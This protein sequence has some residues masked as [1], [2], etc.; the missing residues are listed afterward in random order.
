MTNNRQQPSNAL[1]ND[2]DFWLDMFS[3]DFAVSKFPSDSIQNY[4]SGKG[5]IEYTFQ[6]EL[7]QRLNQMA[8]G[9]EKAFFLILLSGIEYLLYRYTY[10]SPVVVAAPIFK[11]LGEGRFINNFLVYSSW[12]DQNLTFIDLLVQTKTRVSDVVSHQNYPLKNLIAELNFKSTSDKWPL[13]DVLVVLENIHQEQHLAEEGFNVSFRF[14]HQADQLLLRVEYN[15]GLYLQETVEQWVRHLE[16]LLTIVARSPETTLADIDLLSDAEKQKL[17]SCAVDADYPRD[18][19]IQQI[20]GQQVERF[21][22]RVA[23]KYQSPD[24]EQ[25]LELTYRELNQKANT[26]AQRLHSKGVRPGTIVGL[27]V[28]PS[29][30][31]VIGI[32]AILKAGGCYLPID[33]EYPRE[34]VEYMLADSQSSI[35]L[36]NSEIYTEFDYSGEIVNIAD[37]VVSAADQMEL[38]ASSGPND[39][40]Y[41]IYTSGSS[42]KPKGVLVE[43]R[44]VVRLFINDSSPF[45]FDEQ[46]IWLLFHSYCFDFSVWEMYGALLFGGK[47]IIIPRSTA[48]DPGESLRVIIGEGVTILNQTPTAFSNLLTEEFRTAERKLNLRYVIFGGEALK[49]AILREW[50]QRYPETKLINMYGITETTVHVTYKEITEVEIQHNLSNLGRPIPTLQVYILDSDLRLVPRGVIGEIVVGGVGVSRGYLNRP[51]LT[52]EK[53]IPDPFKP[54]NRLYRSGDLGRIL[55]S[56][57]IEY[58]GRRDRQIKIRGFR[59]ELGEVEYRLLSHPAIKTVHL[60]L[61]DNQIGEKDLWAYLVCEGEVTTAELRN[62]LA[63]HLPSYMYP[64]HFLQVDRLPLTDNG[65]IDQQALSIMGNELKVGTD[66]LLPKSHLEKELAELWAEVL[67]LIEVGIN[68][69]F[70]ECGGDS[71]KAVRL[72]TEINRRLDVGLEI[73]DLYRHQT[74]KELALCLEELKEKGDLGLTSVLQRGRDLLAEF[75]NNIANDQSLLKRLPGGMEDFYPLSPIQL[76]MVYYSNIKPEEPVYHDQFVYPVRFVNFELDKFVQSFKLMMSKHPILRTT[77]QMRHFAEPIQIVHRELEPVINFADITDLNRQEQEERINRYLKEED[78]GEKFR[79]ENNPLWRMQLFRVKNHEYYIIFSFHHSILDGWSVANLIPE[80]L[81]IY[82]KL[83]SGLEIQIQKLQHSYQDYVALLLGRKKNQEIGA[84]WQNKLRGYTRSKLPFNLSGKKLHNLYQSKIQRVNLGVELLKKLEEQI[85]VFGCSGKALFL[86]AYLYLL[87]IITTEEEII[88]GVVTNDRPVMEDSDKILGCFL[89]TIPLRLK[90]DKEISKSELIQQVSAYLIDVKPYEIFLGDIAELIGERNHLQNPIFDTIFNYIDFHVLKDVDSE[91]VKTDGNQLTVEPSE[92]TNTLFDLEVS[93]TLGRLKVWIKYSPNYFTD[94]DITTALRLYIRILE[95]LAD[96]R[97]T[98]LRSVDLLTAEEKDWLIYQ[99]NNTDAPYPYQKTIHQLFEERTLANPENPAVKWK[100]QLVSYRELNQRANRLAH[101]LR[102]QGVRTGDHVGLIVERQPDMISGMLGILKAGAV[103]I[104]ID[105]DYPL[106]RKEYILQ[107]SAVSVIVVD[108]PVDNCN[109]DQL[110]LNED[111]LRNY[112]DGNLSLDKDSCDLAYVIFTSGSTGRPKGVMI[113]HHSAV[114]LIV[115][116]NRQFAIGLNDRLLFITSVCFDLSVYDVFGILAAGGQVVIASKAEIRNPVELKKLLITEKITFWDSVPTTLNN[117]INTLNQTDPDYVQP[118]LRLVFLS[119]DWIPVKLPGLVQKYFPQAKVVSL[120]GATEGTVWSI[121]YSIEGVMEGQTSIPYGKP[122]SNNYFYILDENLAPVPTGVAGELFIGG[123]GVAR[124]YLNESE[125]TASSFIPNVFREMLTREQRSHCPRERMLYRTGDLGRMLP[126]GNIEFLGRRDHQVKIRG[127]RVELG[128]II[129]QLLLHDEINQAVVVDRTDLSGDK[130]LCAFLVARECGQELSVRELKEY[131]AREL[132]EY[133]IPTHYLYIDQL[134]LNT[135][136]KIDWQALPEL[137]G[138]LQ[139]GVEYIPPEGDYEKSLADL[140]VE[141]IPGITGIGVFDN[142]FD[143][144]GHSL[145]ATQ[146]ALRIFKEFNVDI[147]LQAI[148]EAENLRDLARRVKLADQRDYIA[149][150]QIEKRDYYPVSSAQKRLYILTQFE[151]NSTAYNMPGALLVEGSVDKTRLELSFTRLIQHHEI[152]R[153][154]FFLKDSDSSGDHKIVA[155]VDG[156]WGELVQQLQPEVEFSIQELTGDLQSVITEFIQPFDL[157]RPPLL[158]VGLLQLAEN[159]HLLVYDLPHIIADGISMGI[160]INDFVQ[161]YEGTQLPPLRIQYKDYAQWQRELLTSEEFAIQEKFWREQFA[162]EVPILNLPTDYSRPKILNYRG[163][164]YRFSLDQELVDRLSI[165]ERRFGVTRFMLLLTIYKIFLAK[166]SSQTDLVVGTPIAGRQDPELEKVI[167]VFVNTLA[168]R[169]Y[170]ALTKN[171][172]EYLLQIKELAVRAYENQDYPFE[173][174]VEQL[175]I[176]RELSRNPL[177]DTMFALQNMPDIE[178]TISDLSFRSYPFAHNVSKFDLTLNAFEVRDG[179]NLHL[180]YSTALFTEATIKRMADN[181]KQLI[182]SV[183]EHPELKLWELEILSERDRERLLHQYNNTQKDY[184]IDKLVTQLFA[185]QVEK[186]PERL[187]LICG[188]EELSYNELYTQ[189]CQL[190]SFL[191]QQGVGRESVVGLMVSRSSR[192]LS[193][194]LGILEAG[195]AYL[196]IDPEYPV[197]RIIYMVQDSGTQII[198]TDSITQQKFAGSEELRERLLVN[199]DDQAIYET[200][201]DSNTDNYLRDRRSSDMIYVIYTSGS[202]GKPKGTVIEHRMVHNLIQGICAKIDFDRKRI[203]S[204]TTVSFDI[205]VLE[206]LLPLTRGAGVVLTRE[207]E[208]QDPGLLVKLVQCKQIEIIQLT[209]SRLQLLLDSVANTGFFGQFTE[210]IVGGETF[211]EQ[212]VERVKKLATGRIFNV[213]GPTETTVWSTIKELTASKEKVTIGRPLANT[214]IYILDNY[215]NPVPEQVVGE[216]FIAGAG[217]ARGYLDR[218]ELT[219]SVF[220][221]DRFA[222]TAQQ[223]MYKTGDLA[224]WLP[225]GEIQFI[226][227]KDRQIKLRGYRIETGEIETILNS[228]PGIIDSIVVAREGVQD[229]KYLV[230]YYLGDLQPTVSELRSYLGEKLP[231][232]M[233]PTYFH[234]LDS[235][236]LTPNGKIDQQALPQIAEERPELSTH[237]AMPESEVE[238][239]IADIWRKIL[240]IDRIGVNDSFFELGG[241]SMLLVQSHLLLEKCFPERL[242]IA[243]LFIYNTIAKLT[244][245]LENI[246][247]QKQTEK[248]DPEILTREA[249]FWQKE[250]VNAGQLLR[251][252]DEYFNLPAGHPEWINLLFELTDD[253]TFQLRAIQELEKV[254]LSDIL[255]AI[256]VYLLSELAETSA[257]WIEVV[258]RNISEKSNSELGLPLWIDLTE[259]E[260]FIQLYREINSKWSMVEKMST[261]CDPPVLTSQ[262][263]QEIIPIISTGEQ[264]EGLRNQHLLLVFTEVNNR[265][266][267]ECGFNSGKLQKGKIEELLIWYVNLLEQLIGEKEVS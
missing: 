182:K 136:G 185:E 99:F 246:N 231:E 210:I 151:G 229:Y 113:E 47:L 65:K 165:L 135:N 82:K 131:L 75:K 195:G 178:L 54:E 197:Q 76:G 164:T 138:Q 217:V 212:L 156:T 265:V 67:E 25:G 177:F 180:E 230:G 74:I 142:F 109:I 237:Y 5:L 242:T 27:L 10:R 12:I 77:Y 219:S 58:L 137:S 114:N 30:E 154:S 6:F 123:V 214:R 216:I 78:L 125:K 119:G 107:K 179:I 255:T 254:D 90:V 13:A 248:L 80:C 238:L 198:L 159:R 122:I 91:Y 208:L 204:L 207:V 49:P 36:C 215:S 128:E 64:T 153:T 41:I 267:I 240:G 111:R 34:R 38:I 264:T 70:S 261:A 256:F 104:P 252:S 87:R 250:M 53:F 187:A 220:L 66:L 117:L 148:F 14:T 56:G 141:L 97:I 115:W 2:H 170:P 262:M 28:E 96:S 44:N 26:L 59:I 92:M 257:F 60:M 21:P 163:S 89:N 171:F 199:I 200:K 118:D 31:M 29:L 83:Q 43:Q 166:Y 127:F 116:V 157:R 149:I 88:T 139:T 234:K 239:L 68:Y 167:G 33:P 143:L 158:R 226:G 249:E 244:E 144:G 108:S 213:Y 145:T 81:A 160:M 196:P 189:V 259:I 24:S 132:P 253:L 146:L 228:F 62:H 258:P 22:E 176:P 45:A 42:G 133:M 174:L 134:P 61:K 55:P 120:G 251:L 4:S 129:N 155:T 181:L 140:W 235:L 112:P 161:L 169:S 94:Q 260:D 98:M 8:K 175:D 52:A 51:E 20:V 7:T 266:Q 211:P 105:P 245:H 192:L 183:V 84:Y 32:L 100:D 35:L 203:V 101:L 233:I 110:H 168:L 48:R 72:V 172:S 71:I 201:S 184:P 16:N 50:Q 152:L 124:G 1:V 39:L 106:A 173:M 222:G 241:N 126:D 79:F 73:K 19:T 130:Y 93:K 209:P 162:G 247:Q 218:P 263:D 63:L 190:A 17:L 95:S 223:H 243:E 9:S 86:S 225:G 18:Q 147:S 102:E 221:P 121:Y 37:S 205:F 15:P 186:T 224:C 57:E 227:R 3:E 103:Y 69:N 232:Y 23:L 85:K 193:G 46:D 11:Q 194:M 202:T 191:R 188:D 40:A 150:R 206:T 236:P